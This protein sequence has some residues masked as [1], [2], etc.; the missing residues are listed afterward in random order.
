M[1]E[2]PHTSPAGLIG[3]ASKA[4]SLRVT[5]WNGKNLRHEAAQ[6]RLILNFFGAR[7]MWTG[8]KGPHALQ[9][10]QL[11]EKR[12]ETYEKMGSVGLRAAPGTA[13]SEEG[14]LSSAEGAVAISW[15]SGEGGQGH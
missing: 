5:G 10:F 13:G 8:K 4:A 9:A 2:K 11:Q 7:K 3:G 12:A 1:A 15:R 6:L 14:I